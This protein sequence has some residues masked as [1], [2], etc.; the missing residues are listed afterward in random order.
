VIAVSRGGVADWY[1]GV[2]ARYIEIFDHVDPA[3][4]ARRNAQR[5]SEYEAGGQ[6]QTRLSAF[7]EEFIG[8]ARDAVGD[9]RAKV[10]HPALMYRLFN[11]FWLG[12][13][14]AD[15]VFRRTSY[16]AA[17]RLA[18][19]PAIAVTPRPD[20]RLPE[21]FIAAKFYTGAALPDTAECRRGLRDLVSLAAAE[22]PV[23]MLDTGMGTDEH[24]DYL[25]ADIPNVFSLRDRLEPR[26]NLGV[27]TAVVAA[28]QRFIGTCGSLAWL[29]PMLGVPTVA[30][31]A[32]ERLLT[33]HLYLARQVFRRMHAA[34]FETLDLGAALELDLLVP[35]AQE[36]AR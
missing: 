9:S 7:D 19:M 1:G 4:F 5:R 21:R 3:A 24:E 12:N 27:Q 15:V 20:L 22:M 30:V 8:I 16:R 28:S 11:Q 32:D 29:A 25:F 6:K 34:P 2:A 23:V 18:S 31:Y 26:T 33:T 10:C 36:S 14:A 35:A 13:R 17:G